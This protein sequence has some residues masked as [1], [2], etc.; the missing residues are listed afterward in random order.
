MQA[1]QR[2]KV[3]S[4]T[5]PLRYLSFFVCL[6]AARAFAAS[7]DA[8]IAINVAPTTIQ[9]ASGVAFSVPITNAGPDFSEN[10]TVRFDSNRPING[11]IANS[12][13]CNAANAEHTSFV[14]TDSRLFPQTVKVQF[15]GD[16]FTPADG[17][18]FDLSASITS[19]TPD[20]EPSNNSASAST[21]VRWQSDVAL[22]T[23][24]H[25]SPTSPGGDV[26]LIF[27]WT[28]NGPSAATTTLTVPAVAGTTFRSVFAPRATCTTPPS[29]GT[30]DVQCTMTIP[31]TADVNQVNL[32][33]R[34]DANA[35]SSIYVSGSISS[36]GDTTPNNNSASTSIPIVTNANLEAVI[37]GPSTIIAGLTNTY[38]ATI[39]N[40]GPFDGK[41]VSLQM[42][43]TP[44]SPTPAGWTCTKSP[45]GATCRADTLASDAHA[46]FRLDITAP[47]SAL[48]GTTS[49][50]RVSLTASNDA[51]SFNNS[52]MLILTYDT[53]CDLALAA[54]APGLI[55]AGADI[56]VTFSFSDNG[57]SEARGFTL[58]Y[59][60]PLGVTFQSLIAS[61]AGA[62]VPCTFPP[63]G[64]SGR[65]T[66]EFARSPI[67]INV[68]A[69]QPGGITNTATMVSALT[70]DPD[71]SNN[72][73][74][75]T[76]FVA[77]A[78]SDLSVA[79]SASSGSIPLG[80]PVVYTITVSNNGASTPVDII[81]ELPP[82]IVPLSASSAC[83]IS[84]QTIRCSASSLG[85]GETHTFAITGT[86]RAAGPIANTATLSPSGQT[87][88]VTI[89][90]ILGR[91]RSAR[92]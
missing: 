29:G 66:C 60:T 4:Q 49:T 18:Q 68:R 19:S 90:G 13:R 62:N 30:G 32:I 22:D 47:R 23:I 16:P 51:T 74:S 34:V 24:L 26:S 9:S 33:L 53:L 10:V 41:N 76:T 92:H 25:S 89:T 81:D 78:T 69:A 11:V 59:D 77:A 70:E 56:P 43:A 38:I 39:A 65:V 40:H 87:A 61:P 44:Q 52:S 72:I 37:N 85:T 63:A 58:I 57:P 73:A 35:P 2:P 42:P 80:S 84:G 50:L 15:D 21:T 28:N 48:K 71:L 8:G 12:F 64:S 45:T 88:S 31:S 27:R 20:P 67:I 17:T 6:F 91:S 36:P 14:C 75:A 83:S 54:S 3:M 7:A 1:V 86:V 82:A 79:M 46:D 5:I 55:S